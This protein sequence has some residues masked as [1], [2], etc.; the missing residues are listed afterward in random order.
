MANIQIPEAL[1]YDILRYYII[2]SKGE[3]VPE[4]LDKRVFDGLS[5]KNTSIAGVFPKVSDG[6]KTNRSVLR[7]CFCNLENVG[8]TTH[9]LSF[10]FLGNRS[11]IDFIDYLFRCIAMFRIP[12]FFPYFS[13]LICGLFATF[14]RSIVDL[15]YDLLFGYQNSLL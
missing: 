5:D 9:H 6:K 7:S 3:D 1:F 13:E 14:F 12:I 10:H 8:G 2:S 4:E 15:I 11:F